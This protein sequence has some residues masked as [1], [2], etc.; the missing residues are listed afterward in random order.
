MPSPPS[1]PRPRGTDASRNPLPPATDLSGI[2]VT[3]ISGTGYDI[4]TTT[5]VTDTSFII[6]TVFTSS[7][8][9]GVVDITENLTE[10]VTMYVDDVDPSGQNTV[11][12]QQI[13]DYASQ[14]NCDS[15]HGKGTV[16]D[17][18][19]LFQAASNIANETAQMQ[20]NVDVDGFN[21]F[22]VAAD[23]L[24]TLFQSFTVKLQSVNI[25]N[26]TAFLSAIAHALGRIVHLSN[27]FG[28]FKE[29]ILQTSTIKIPKSTYDTRVVL[30]GVMGEIACAMDHIQYFVDPSSCSTVLTDA[31]LTPVEKNIIQQ[32]VH[33][34]DQWNVICQQGVTIA[35]GNDPDV[36][37]I[38]QA[39]AQ[40][41]LSTASLQQA[42]ST[43]R[44]KIAAWIP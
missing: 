43:L 7:D 33:T 28:K 15:F 36:Q 5:V 42:T 26:D 27:V 8:P 9:S 3:D 21:A 37:Y 19:V 41:Q 24:S 30:E 31:E 11:L 20:L 40:I 12:I 10:N 32:A 39:N 44:N 29:T 13:R 35:M 23:E 25:I 38:S 2:S 18:A 34:I 6:Q 14:I 4:L 16:D 1:T 22:A 17:Y